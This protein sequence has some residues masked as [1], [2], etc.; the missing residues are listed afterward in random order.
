MKEACETFIKINISKSSQ[1]IKNQL[2]IIQSV[3][4]PSRLMDFQSYKEKFWIN[5]KNS[6]FMFNA[7]SKSSRYIVLLPTDILIPDKILK[8]K[9]CT[10]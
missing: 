2:Y 3:F 5:V 7:R 8:A 9:Q 10:A 1:P 6:K 4:Q